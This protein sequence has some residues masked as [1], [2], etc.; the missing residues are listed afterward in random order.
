MSYVFFGRLEDNAF[1][2]SLEC[3]ADSEP[4]LKSRG[5][6]VCL[7]NQCWILVAPISCLTVVSYEALYRGM[8]HMV[9]PYG[10]Y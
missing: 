3:T 6:I 8:R 2:H 7:A 4:A 1:S 10:G 9:S 5:C